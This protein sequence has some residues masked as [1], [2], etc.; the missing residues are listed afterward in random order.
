MNLLT[1]HGWLMV[2]RGKPLA[3]KTVSGYSCL[4]STCSPVRFLE[5]V[6]RRRQRGCRAAP[7]RE[8]GPPARRTTTPAE[9]HPT[10]RLTIER[11]KPNEGSFGRLYHRVNR[12]MAVSEVT[13]GSRYLGR[14]KL[15][16]DIFSKCSRGKGYRNI[17]TYL[18]RYRAMHRVR[19]DNHRRD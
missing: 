6:S 8:T 1:G 2:P 4:S 12:Q 16:I 10:T 14:G 9:Q 15:P 19:L 3:W 13:F 11:V 7:S 5:H 18:H 17:S